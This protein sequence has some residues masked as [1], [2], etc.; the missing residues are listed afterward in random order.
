[1]NKKVCYFIS[2]ILLI[3]SCNKS[4]ERPCWKSN[5]NKITITTPFTETFKNIELNDDVNLIL[6]NDSLNFF[7]IEGPENLVEHINIHSS[8]EKITISNSNLCDFLR[9]PKT[10]NVYCHYTALKNIE[11]LGYGTL[12]NQ[13]L[14]QHNINIHTFESLSN[15]SLELQNDSTILTLLKGAVDVKLKGTS[16]YLY[17]YASGYGPFNADSLTC[18]KAHGHSRGLGNFYLNAT[19]SLVI[20]LRSQGNFYYK[21]N[22]NS[23][24]FIQTGTGLIFNMN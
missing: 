3:Y 22:P 8:D 5:G 2:I 24:N 12:S 19:N 15:I 4:N 6:I 23:L 13:D 9:S 17:G 1:M 7:D 21:G 18:F 16:N 10:I 14:I 20:E 11:L